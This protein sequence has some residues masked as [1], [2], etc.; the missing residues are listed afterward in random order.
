MDAVNCKINDKEPSPQEQPAVSVN[1][2][3]P[4]EGSRPSPLQAIPHMTNR[5]NVGGQYT[6][7]YGLSPVRLYHATSE[8][9]E[10]PTVVIN[11]N[12]LSDMVLISDGEFMMGCN[13]AVDNNCLE[14]EKPYHR[15][16]L[17]NYY[18]DKHEVTV[19]EYQGCVNAGGCNEPNTG[20][21]CNWGQSGREDH[22]INCVNWNQAQT[23]CRWAGKRLPTEAEWE[24]AARGTDGRKYPWGNETATFQYAVMSDGGDGCGRNSTWPVCSKPQGN[25]PYGLCD[26]AGN[27]VEWVED[28]YEGNYYQGSAANNPTGPSTGKDR[29]L[30][31]GSWVHGMPKYLRTAYRGWAIPAISDNDFGLRWVRPVQ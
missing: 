24:K 2:I 14:I 5:Y 23:Y 26:M 12:K 19:A 29:V 31:G 7:G 22:P 18:I 21:Y 13:E 25:S 4:E 8:L 16:Y 30:R 10:K 9:R 20:K 27:V 28:W 3:H 17:N 11:K 1:G 15:V 6:Q